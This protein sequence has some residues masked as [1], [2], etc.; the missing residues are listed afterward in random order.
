MTAQLVERAF[1]ER[2][3]LMA[4]VHVYTGIFLPALARDPR[5]RRVLERTRLTDVAG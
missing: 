4:C 5:F 2:D 1:E 3:P